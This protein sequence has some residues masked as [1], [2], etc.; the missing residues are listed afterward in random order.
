MNDKTNKSE[1][2]GGNEIDK[3]QAK[4]TENIAQASSEQSRLA[5]LRLEFQNEYLKSLELRSEFAKKP[6][7]VRKK[8]PEELAYHATKKEFGEFRPDD[9]KAMES[10][11]NN[12]KGADVKLPDGKSVHLEN[13]AELYDK[14]VAFN[15]EKGSFYDEKHIKEQAPE[16]LQRLTQTNS[17][18][19]IARKALLAEFPVK[20]DGNA[21]IK[22]LENQAREIHKDVEKLKKVAVS[23]AKT[24]VTMGEADANKNQDKLVKPDVSSK[25]QV[26]AQKLGVS[27][28]QVAELRIAEA[29][30]SA[31]AKEQTK[32]EEWKQVVKEG[33]AEV[34]RLNNDNQ[35]SV[36]GPVT[37]PKAQ[38]AIGSGEKSKV[39]SDQSI[40]AERVGDKPP[41][42]IPD[43]LNKKYIID[44]DNEKGK[45]YFKEKP[46]VEA[47]RDKGS[48]LLTTST[49]TSVAKSMVALA[50][51]KQWEKI[52]LSGTEKF[53][54]EVWM[55]AK[56]RGMEVD[57]YKP[58][59]QDLQN[60]EGRLNKI[61]SASE[62]KQPSTSSRQQELK[63]DDK[64]PT[65]SNVTT[66]VALN[67]ALNS[68]KSES[69]LQDAPVQSNSLADQKARDKSREL[70]EQEKA[71]QK[72]TAA[73]TEPVKTADQKV[74]EMRDKIHLGQK[75]VESEQT[76]SSNSDGQP[77]QERSKK[78]ELRSAYM[79]LSKEEAVKKHPELEPLYNLE[80][81]ASQFVNHERNKGKFD[82][83]GKQK[84]IDAVREKALDTLDK[85]NK[86]PEV[87]T[88]VVESH[89]K[90]AERD[91]EIAR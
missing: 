64:Q 35:P 89:A 26:I 46:D 37:Q 72:Q 65:L 73:T 76:T 61:E 90:V 43:E 85:G 62:V 24:A 27:S 28:E 81:A 50:E 56:L 9:R 83:K 67:A 49:A 3:P 23:V 87:Q 88:K 47:F 22:D 74:I 12:G 2:S 19:S 18:V 41:K 4:Q 53:R 11:T 58:S 60:L 71:E 42:P 54:R 40:E 52:K 57:G 14:V 63:S 8:S 80:K 59:Q 32:K 79:E 82:N 34:S 6:G 10:N 51:T 39:E 29:N 48:K 36:K 84:F 25:D 31:K 15:K 66:K 38:P 13:Q 77:G 7:Y 21:V 55:E 20:K 68:E 70:W 16:D 91:Q 45:Y 17:A 1:T 75:G 78:D 44:G 33:E 86:L 5:T 69:K 30:A